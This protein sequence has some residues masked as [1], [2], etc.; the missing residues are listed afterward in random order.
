MSADLYRQANGAD[1]PAFVEPTGATTSFAHLEEAVVRW[2]KARQ[3]IPNAKPHVQLMKTGS[4]LGELFDAEI[5]GDTIGIIDGVGD[6]LVTLIIYCELHKLSLA[7]CLHAAYDEIKDRKGTLLPN[8]CFVK[9][10]S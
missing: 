6:V 5:K 2:A 1:A 7:G 10:A 8:G 4:E 9:D 3:I